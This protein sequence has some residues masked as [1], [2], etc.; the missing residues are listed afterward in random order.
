M[1]AG[2]VKNGKGFNPEVWTRWVNARQSQAIAGAVEF[3]NY[4]NSHKRVQCFMYLIVRI[5]LKKLQ[6]LMI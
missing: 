1:L 3:N 4:V 6:Q 2:K 5:Q